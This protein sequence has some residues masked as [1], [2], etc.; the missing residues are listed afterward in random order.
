MRMERHS[1]HGAIREIRVIAVQTCSA[2]PR[3]ELLRR[4]AEC[5][6]SSCAVTERGMRMELYF[7]S[8]GIPHMNIDWRHDIERVL[9]DAKAQHKPVLLDFS[10]APM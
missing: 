10:A 4:R 9:A 8:S 5:L 2:P 1:P 7:L 3:N 6:L